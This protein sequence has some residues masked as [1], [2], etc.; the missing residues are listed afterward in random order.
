M[1]IGGRTILILG[2]AG[3]VGMAVARKLL[4]L[5]PARVVLG[6]LTQREAEEAIAALEEDNPGGSALE[7]VW[8][9]MFLP[10]ALKDRRRRDVLADPAARAMVLDEMYGNLTDEVVERSALGA[11]LLR[12]HPDIIV[13]C[14]N[15]AT[16]FA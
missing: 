8:G 6:G 9:D 14:V 15:T 11:L 12:V 3:L 5:T 10:A 1:D 7:A 2:G 16:A 13:D 4:E